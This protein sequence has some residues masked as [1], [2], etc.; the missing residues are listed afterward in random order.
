MA[1]SLP[2][3]ARIS[4]RFPA[5]CATEISFQSRYP[6]GILIPKIGAAAPSACSD[7]GVMWATA[8]ASAMTATRTKAIR[9]IQCLLY[10]RGPQTRSAATVVVVASTLIMSA[11]SLAIGI[12]RG[13]DPPEPDFPLHA[14][15]KPSDRP[16]RSRLPC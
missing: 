13:E 11:V 3:I 14:H 6:A 2:K 16:P 12:L 15:G 8:P 9:L 1:L 5:S 7:A 4:F 10:I